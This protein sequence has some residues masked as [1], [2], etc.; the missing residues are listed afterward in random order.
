[1]A[2]DG[3]SA[4]RECRA[5]LLSSSEKYDGAH[6]SRANERVVVDPGTMPFQRVQGIAS[7]GVGAST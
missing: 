7:G 6:V 3:K 2:A 5:G 4:P 1:M